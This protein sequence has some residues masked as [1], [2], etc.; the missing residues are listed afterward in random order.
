ML[1]TLQS[2]LDFIQTAGIAVR[3]L[4]TRQQWD[5]QKRYSTNTQQIIHPVHNQS[6][7][8]IWFWDVFIKFSMI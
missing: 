2:E 1:T 4:K 3:D 5:L 8:M 7:Q 6:Q